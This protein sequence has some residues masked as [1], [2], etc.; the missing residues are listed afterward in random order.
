MRARTEDTVEV[1]ADKVNNESAPYLKVLARQ[2]LGDRG[3]SPGLSKRAD[4]REGDFESLV[5]LLA[6]VRT[7][8]LDE[9]AQAVESR[10]AVEWRPGVADNTVHRAMRDAAAVILRAMGT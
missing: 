9:A 6:R 1:E 4:I 2:W 3:L 5:A 8:A 10:A 7:V